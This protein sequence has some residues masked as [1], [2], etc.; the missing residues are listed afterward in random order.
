VLVGSFLQFVLEFRFCSVGFVQVG[1]FPTGLF[2]CSDLDW[3]FVVT[4][5]QLNHYRYRWL[6]YVV[7]WFC[8]CY[9]FF[10]LDYT[11]FGHYRFWVHTRLF[12]DPSYLPI[13]PTR[14]LHWLHIWTHLVCWVV[15]VG[16][17]CC[18]IWLVVGWVLY[19]HTFYRWD[20][21]VVALLDPIV[22]GLFR[23][24]LRGQVR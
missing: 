18:Y 7:S 13:L 8:Y 16:C 15:V 22:I 12:L 24:V 1:W 17:C 4:V 9:R 2:Y 19:T 5:S 11:H 3:L 14:L 23:L 20:G 6:I 10:E 21:S